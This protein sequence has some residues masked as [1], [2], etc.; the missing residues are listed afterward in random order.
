MRTYALAL[1]LPLPAIHLAR[2]SWQ[3]WYIDLRVL[4]YL[5]LVLLVAIEEFLKCSRGKSNS[6]CYQRCEERGNVRHA[7]YVVLIHWSKRR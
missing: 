4:D 1:D 3:I 2:F 7:T 6:F 5:E